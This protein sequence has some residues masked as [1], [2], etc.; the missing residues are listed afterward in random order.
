MPRE[1]QADKFPEFPV[2]GPVQLSNGACSILDCDGPE[3]NLMTGHQGGVSAYGL[4]RNGSEFVSVQY[5]QVLVT[6]ADI[7]GLVASGT[8]VEN[9]RES[10]FVGLAKPPTCSSE[11][12]LQ[13]Y[14]DNADIR[15]MSGAFLNLRKQDL[16]RNGLT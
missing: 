12:K 11:N 8:W 6:P 4:C 13:I 14:P 9:G 5:V 10:V 1:Q 16:P 7:G 2:P 15:G 3:C